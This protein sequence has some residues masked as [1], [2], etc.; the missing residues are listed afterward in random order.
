MLAFQD[1]FFLSTILILVCLLVGFNE[2]HQIDW[3]LS[4]EYDVAIF[5][6]TRV[7]FRGNHATLTNA[8]RLKQ[9]IL[10]DLDAPFSFCLERHNCVIIKP[11]RE[12]NMIGIS[13]MRQVSILVKGLVPGCPM[14]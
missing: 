1:G 6:T 12:I 13:S 4:D 8:H 3:A 11:I 14:H 9:V 5:E 2:G 10:T 7:I